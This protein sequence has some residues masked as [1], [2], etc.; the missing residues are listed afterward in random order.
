MKKKAIIIGIDGCRPDSMLVAK[1]PQLDALWRGGA[2]SFQ[3]KTDRI[4]ISGP[5]WTSVL[6]GVWHEKHGILDN[7]YS[8]ASQVPHF[9]ERAKA[10][11]STLK[12][13]SIV[14]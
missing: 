1:T 11:N 14:Q 12:F 7:K 9:F 8:V 6:T 10:Y 3:A 13:A 2:Y 5:C 4:T